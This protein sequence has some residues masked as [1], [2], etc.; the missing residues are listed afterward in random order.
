M[1]TA[2][3]YRGNDSSARVIT[4]S[5]NV[6]TPFPDAKSAQDCRQLRVASGS[7]TVY[8]LSQ[9]RTNVHSRIIDSGRLESDGSGAGDSSFFRQIAVVLEGM[10]RVKT[11]SSRGGEGDLVV[12]MLPNGRVAEPAEDL[13][14]PLGPTA[15]QNLASFEL[16]V[17]G[18][19]IYS[20]KG[21]AQELRLPA[22]RLKP[23]TQITWKLSYGGKPY[24]GTFTVEPT[25]NLENLKQRLAQESASN[26]DPLV[27]QLQ[28]ASILLLEGY[29]WDARQIL[30]ASLAP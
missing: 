2:C 4:Q 20:Q 1:A 16:R 12:A 7:V 28:L 24:E 10:Q 26:A 15:D 17:N 27:S 6:I 19:S 9:D 3:M 23:G 25:A 13:R 14:I 18:K 21:P 11:G 30:K 8:E 22:S 29:Q 5:G